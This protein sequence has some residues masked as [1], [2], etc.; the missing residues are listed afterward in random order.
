MYTIW[1]IEFRLKMWRCWR[2]KKSEREIQV[3]LSSVIQ[4]KLER[5]KKLAEVGR[6]RKFFCIFVL[7]DILIWMFRSGF[8]KFLLANKFLWMNKWM[9]A[10]LEQ[11]KKNGRYHSKHVFVVVVFVSINVVVVVVVIVILRSLMDWQFYF[12]FFIMTKKKWK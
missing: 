2:W 4:F 6:K 5:R 12:Y 1:P 11:T 9:M 3:F 8:S 7:F 10:I